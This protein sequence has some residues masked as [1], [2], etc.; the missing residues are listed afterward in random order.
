MR[1][2]R[3]RGTLI[4]VVI[5]SLIS[6]KEA[7]ENA[8][9]ADSTASAELSATATTGATA[10]TSDG[11]EGSGSETDPAPSK[12]PEEAP[13]EAS[14]S[15]EPS[16]KDPPKKA[17]PSRLSLEGEAIQGGLLTA[18]VEPGTR[19]IKFPGHRVVIADD[20]TFLIAFS[21]NAPP[22]EVLTITFPDGAVL[23]HEF[24]VAQRSF[25]DDR[26]DGLPESFVK[27]PPAT[28]KKLRADNARIDQKRMG[29][30][31]T[32]H[33]AEGFIWPC[34]GKITSR[35]GQKRFLNGIDSGF[36]W[37][38]DVA[39]PVGTPV[40]APAGGTVIF[41]EAGI[42]LAGTMVVID[43][44]HGLSSSLLHLATITAKVGQEVARGD[45]VGTVGMTGRTNGPHLDWRMNFFEIRIDPELL[46]PPMPGG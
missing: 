36:H 17:D 45:V 2:H 7:D 4:F 11:D 32:A 19:G 33:Y 35:Y 29:Y 1:C 44:G 20:G 16:A 30:T 10:T 12:P 25:E 26:I 37:G 28:Q 39:V 8:A 31:K 43:H 27:L 13:E 23:E 42:P 22:K 41:A 5:A 38:V 9:G 6:C 40:K 18:K 14:A 21:R 34:V 24:S 46:A 3:N 15:P